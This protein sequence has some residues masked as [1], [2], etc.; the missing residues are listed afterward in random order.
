MKAEISDAEGIQRSCCEA[1]CLVIPVSIAKLIESGKWHDILC[2]AR[3]HRKFPRCNLPLPF[4]DHWP[5]AEWFPSAEESQLVE[6]GSMPNAD[7][8]AKSIATLRSAATRILHVSSCEETRAACLRD[9]EGLVAKMS[10]WGFYLSSER[11]DYPMV[12]AARQHYAAAK[13]VE[14]IRC[15]RKLRGGARA[16]GAIVE[17]ALAIV[18]SD[19][20]F[21]TAVL[22]DVALRL[23]S[24]STIWRG[25]LSLDVSL[26]LLRAQEI[27]LSA[28]MSRWMLADSSPQQSYDWVWTE[29]N[30]LPRNSL[31]AVFLAVVSLSLMVDKLCDEYKDRP[32]DLSEVI[33]DGLFPREWEALH[34]ALEELRHHICIPVSV[35]SGHRG[36]VHKC[37]ALSHQLLMDCQGCVR[38]LEAVLRSVR[39][40]TSDMGTEMGIPDFRC[41]DPQELLPPWHGHFE[42]LQPD[43]DD[44]IDDPASLDF[45][46]DVAE[47][48]PDLVCDVAELEP[49]APL[50]SHAQSAQSDDDDGNG[51]F[52]DLPFHSVMP[53][54]LTVSGLQHTIDNLTKEVHTQL[55]W[56]NEFH[57]HL[58][59]FQGFFKI[60]EHRDRFIK[61][62]L[63]GTPHERH[64]WRFKRWSATLYEKRW[65]ETVEF[66]RALM[67]R[68]KF[69]RLAWSEGK[70]Y[71]GV[72]VAREGA[73]RIFDPHKMTQSLCS[74]LFAAYAEMILHVEEVVT[75]L[76]H[77]AEDCPCHG[78]F[79]QHGRQERK[80]LNNARGVRR[81]HVFKAFTHRRSVCP[82]S[83]LRAPEL[84]A[85]MLQD[86]FRALWDVHLSTFIVAAAMSNVGI[87][88]QADMQ[89]LTNDLNL[90]QASM[91]YQLQIKLDYWQRLPW[92]LVALAHVDEAVARRCC[93]KALEDFLQ[94]PDRR[95]HHRI[96]WE[97]M[98][99]DGLLFAD[100]QA[101]A[102]GAPRFSLSRTFIDSV[103]NFRFI[104]LVET[105]IERKHALVRMESQR[106]LGP[107]R[108]SLSNRLQ[109]LE[110]RIKADPAMLKNFCD[111]FSRARTILAIPSLL[112]FQN[113]PGI[114]GKQ[115]VRHWT[116]LIPDVTAAVYRT[117]IADIFFSYEA[118]GKYHERMGE[119]NKKVVASLVE[120]VQDGGSGG[121]KDMVATLM[122]EHL[123][124][125]A[126]PNFVFTSG[127]RSLKV[128]SLASYLS[129]PYAL[130]NAVTKRRR[131][132]DVGEPQTTP[133][134]P[135]LVSDVAVAE[136]S[137]LS[138]E[139]VQPQR[140]ADANVCAFRV[141]KADTSHQKQLNVQ[142]GAGRKMSGEH[143]AVTVH[144]FEGS[145]GSDTAFI[146]AR[147]SQALEELVDLA[148]VRF[149]DS[150]SV[151]DDLLC[152]KRQGLFYRMPDRAKETYGRFNMASEIATQMVERSAYRFA[153][154][155]VRRDR[156]FRPCSA[157][158]QAILN[159]WLE[160]E[161]VY[162]DDEG[163]PSSWFLTEAGLARLVPWWI[164]G[165]PRKIFEPRNVPVKEKTKYEIML[166][167]QAS[168]WVWAQWKPPSQRRKG[169]VFPDGYSVGDAKIWFSSATVSRNYL[170]ALALAEDLL[171][172]YDIKQI[173]HG[174]TDATYQ[175]LLEG[176]VCIQR[177]H[178]RRAGMTKDVD[179][180]V[181]G[182]GNEAGDEANDDKDED[183]SAI[184]YAPTSPAAA[185]SEPQTPA[186]P[187]APLTP[188][189]SAPTTCGPA[190]LP[191]PPSPPAPAPTPPG[192]H[193]D[194]AIDSEDEDDVPPPALPDDDQAA[195]I[196]RTGKFGVF[197]LTPKQPSRRYTFGGFQARCPFHARSKVTG[198]K[199]FLPNVGSTKQ[200]SNKV[201]D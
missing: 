183:A 157:A 196:L 141:V 112:G 89:V 65:H 176:K 169:D 44:A 125:L 33:M 30:E 53:G 140:H 179:D 52:D 47:K 117:G 147:P 156:G 80:R 26:C 70:W 11:G 201:T 83:G 134:S 107:V 121:R 186:N 138:P 15:G 148:L 22:G 127:M 173:V 168:G 137:H 200:D 12:R 16:L 84:A 198:C 25:E 40:Y 161:Y 8:I 108:V 145:V 6:S 144:L 69:L 90:C 159:V 181:A 99:L 37:A 41:Q 14:C 3:W 100:L 24:F 101:F 21:R 46:C 75:G 93:R 95:L 94:A 68:L 49:E 66:V 79:L 29:Y 71:A 7:S 109:I 139:D 103:A 142:A 178:G 5:G 85:D 165:K 118:A 151:R 10:S 98:R 199:K 167:L 193:G 124:Q 81:A 191:E 136:Q 115:Q 143:I 197:T 36:L 18:F 172:Q 180:D 42:E 133:V 2:M 190:N 32:E 195:V 149:T 188:P 97:W 58:K 17:H 150:E 105:T 54:A 116:L 194:E 104:S 113:H 189:A 19:D 152:W 67:W 132:G 129:V 60:K 87:L 77:W 34:A 28:H 38:L 130:G 153:D 158:E 31:K 102:D 114:R 1:P 170:L 23:P 50:L 185:Q 64:S 9:F 88:T 123:Q 92:I 184:S 164:I 106:H 27:Q 57:E 128:Q 72:D 163:E 13:L 91:I 61:T 192:D 96:T 110:D 62:C 175:K 154:I 74:P 174:A 160:C 76:T 51:P 86:I 82:C 131:I 20:V 146:E 78:R 166:H 122:M 4:G 119:A 73:N 120:D 48:S 39:S 43:V 55:E 171:A 126:L 59:N 187:P 155:A 45:A 135:V 35:T 177:R 162:C 63:V 111:L 56:W 182:F